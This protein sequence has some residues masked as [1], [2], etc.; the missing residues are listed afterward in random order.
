M[1]S[2]D[3]SLPLPHEAITKDSSDDTSKCY[4][5]Q[6]LFLRILEWQR[7]Q[8]PTPDTS[9]SLESANNFDHEL[10]TKHI[11]KKRNMVEDSG[12][13]RSTSPG[14]RA[15]VSSREGESSESDN[16]ANADD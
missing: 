6:S 14:K 10:E 15:R 2:P 8:L 4:I 13:W 12:R 3:E 5:D 9:A 1:I 11:P 7:A 16:E